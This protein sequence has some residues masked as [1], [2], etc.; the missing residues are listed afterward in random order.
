MLHTIIEEG[1]TDQQYIQAHTSGFDDLK[2]MVKHFSPEAMAKVCGIDAATIRAVARTFALSER[3]I[4]FW[5]MGVSRHVHG[6]DISRCLIA[7]NLIRSAERRVGKE[8]C[9]KVG[10]P[11]ADDNSK[12]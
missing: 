12:K 10:T 7:L 9:S 5:G 3:S 8:C 6:T 11:G 4:I 2:K 1:L